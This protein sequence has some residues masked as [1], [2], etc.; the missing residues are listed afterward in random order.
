MMYRMLEI[1]Q[2]LHIFGSKRDNPESETH[3]IELLSVST[4]STVMDPTTVKA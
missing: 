1:A 2:K 3:K 4:G